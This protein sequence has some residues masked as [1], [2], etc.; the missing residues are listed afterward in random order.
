MIPRRQ[1]FCA[2]RQL[3]RGGSALGGVAAAALGHQDRRSTS[4]EQSGSGRFRY[5]GAT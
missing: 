2:L 3:Q 4:A 5:G 1:P